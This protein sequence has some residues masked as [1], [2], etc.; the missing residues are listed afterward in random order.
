MPRDM[1]YVLLR[2]SYLGQA[3]GNTGHQGRPEQKLIRTPCRHS[4]DFER[5]WMQFR[6]PAQA[7]DII[8][9]NGG[10]AHLGASTTTNPRKG[11]GFNPSTH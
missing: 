4:S 9:G 10:A 2:R 5:Y 11:H 8:P 3:I 6:R 7:A 1:V